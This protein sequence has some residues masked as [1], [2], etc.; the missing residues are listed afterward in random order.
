MVPDPAIQRSRECDASQFRPTDPRLR[1]MG[2]SERHGR[3]NDYQP[4]QGAGYVRPSLEGRPLAKVTPLDVQAVYGKIIEKGLSARTVRYTHAV[5]RSALQQ[6]VKWRLLVYNP[7]DSVEPPRQ[8]RKEIQVLS[9]VQTRAFLRAADKDRIGALFA[10]AVTAGPRP[11]E[12][13]ALKWTDLNMKA[14]TI[15]VMRSLE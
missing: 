11:S 8:S 1:Q 6:A 5:L 10:L 14:G 7:A 2:E 3:G 12:Y 15:V 4:V 9:T 13:L